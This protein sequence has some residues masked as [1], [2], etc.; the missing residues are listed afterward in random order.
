MLILIPDAPVFRYIGVITL[1]LQ[2][3]RTPFVLN[4]MFMPNVQLNISLHCT[5]NIFDQCFFFVI[6][7]A[8]LQN[9]IMTKANQN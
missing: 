1:L 4:E 8:V 5:D 9:A 2:D 7:N 3:Q 6:R